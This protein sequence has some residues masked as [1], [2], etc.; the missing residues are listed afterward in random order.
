ME[1]LC[2]RKD[3][4][5]GYFPSPSPHHVSISPGQGL[6]LARGA[7]AGRHSGSTCAGVG[8]PVSQWRRDEARKGWRGRAPSL[9]P[10][11]Q[12]KGHCFLLLWERG[13]RF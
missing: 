9:L 7:V 2:C 3:R 11:A 4:K 12:M 1:G 6:Q 10:G 5:E 8:V 13:G